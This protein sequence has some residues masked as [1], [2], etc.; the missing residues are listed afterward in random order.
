MEN[1]AEHLHFLREGRRPQPATLKNYRETPIESK[2]QRPLFF[3]KRQTSLSVRAIQNVI[4][5]KATTPAILVTPQPTPEKLAFDWTLSPKDIRLV[6]KHR[7]HENLL[8]PTAS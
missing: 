3:S 4:A 1:L 5:E 8:P 2:P 7:G 6:L